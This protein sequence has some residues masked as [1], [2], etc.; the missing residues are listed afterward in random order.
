[1]EQLLTLWVDDL[2]K[3]NPLN[4]RDIATKARGLLRKFNKKKVK[5][6]HSLL[7]KDSLQGSNNARK[8]IA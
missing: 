2:N 3:K 7:V 8:F 6:R 5:T 4:R 1:M